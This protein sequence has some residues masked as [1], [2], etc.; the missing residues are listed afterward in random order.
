LIADQF[1]E[2]KQHFLFGG[3][4]KGFNLV[5]GPLCFVFDASWEQLSL[6]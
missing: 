6:T 3:M 4:K 2:E 1:S 5:L